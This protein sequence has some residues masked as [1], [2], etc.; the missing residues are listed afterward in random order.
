VPPHVGF[1]S[2]VKRQKDAPGQCNSEE[3]RRKSEV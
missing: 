2:F 1:S 3:S